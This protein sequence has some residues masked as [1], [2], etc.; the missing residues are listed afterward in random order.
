MV[1]VVAIEE[2]EVREMRETFFS[3]KMNMVKM[4]VD[5]ILATTGAI[6]ILVDSH[7][8]VLIKLT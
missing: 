2:E 4:E 7:L 8:P 6:D 3:T 5:S 1:E